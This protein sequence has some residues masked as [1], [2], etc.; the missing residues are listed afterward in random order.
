MLHT[1]FI[2]DENFVIPT[3]VAISSLIHNNP[4]KELKVHVVTPG[5]SEQAEKTLRGMST[6]N[7][8]VIVYNVENDLNSMSTSGLFDGIPANHTALMKF[9]LPLILKD[10][11]KL[12]YL[13]GDLIVNGDI[14]PIWDVELGD[15]LVAGVCDSIAEWHMQK[16]GLKKYFNSGVM[17][18]NLKKMRD[19]NYSQKLIDY[20]QNGF[21]CFMDQDT[22]NAVFKNRVKYLDFKY[23]TMYSVLETKSADEI[24]SFY[25]MKRRTVNELIDDSVI[26]HFSSSKKPWKYILPGL[27]LLYGKYVSLSP[28]KG[29]EFAYL[30]KAKSICEEE[31]F[32]RYADL[33]EDKKISVIVPAH[34][35]ED[36]VK[37]CVDSI[38]NQTLK[39]IE[40][41]IVDDAST[42]STPE[43][44]DEYAKKDSRVRVIH[45]ETNVGTCKARKLGVEISTGRFIMFVDGDDSIRLDSCE[46]L[47]NE[48]LVNDYDIL[49]FKTAVVANGSN[50]NVVKDFEKYINRSFGFLTSEELIEKSF[51]KK[52]L[53]RN[54]WNR[55]YKGNIVRCAMRDLADGYYLKSEDLYTSLLIAFE[56]KNIGFT[57]TEGYIYSMGLGITSTTSAISVD[58]YKNICTGIDVVKCIADYICEHHNDKKYLEMMTSLFTHCFTESNWWLQYVADVDVEQCLDICFTKYDALLPFVE[59]EMM[60]IS[61]AKALDAMFLTVKKAFALIERRVSDFISKISSNEEIFE[62]YSHIYHNRIMND[63]GAVNI[64]VNILNKDFP[65]LVVLLESIYQSRREDKFYNIYV[66]GNGIYNKNMD[67]THKYNTENMSVRF[68]NNCNGVST[69]IRRGIDG[70]L[71]YKAYA[72]Y[73]L[74]YL[75]K[76]IYLSYDSTVI[77][78][79]SKLADIDLD[80]KIFAAVHDYSL[81]NGEQIASSYATNLLLIDRVAFKKRNVVEAYFASNSKENERGFLN[82]EFAGMIKPLDL[83]WCFKWQIPYKHLNGKITTE[84]DIIQWG[85]DDKPWK[86]PHRIYADVFWKYARSTDFYEEIL[87]ENSSHRQIAVPKQEELAYH[88]RSLWERF[89]IGC[90][91]IGFFATVKKA[92]KKAFRKVFKRRR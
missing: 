74:Q 92:I 70:N 4:Q 11:D 58:K 66:F 67:R 23:N 78:D 9:N 56:S 43:I 89:K 61:L 25:G 1:A 22:F 36:S 81:D 69:N 80:G 87:Y 45:C 48:M 57:D 68:V 17:L 29:H 41:I 90:R 21:N 39:D 54:L 77:G 10:V 86:S 75:D 65:Y 88:Q 51:V 3:S 42:D 2:C 20:R 18:L 82:K 27:C 91:E 7:S 53:S 13:D 49:Q 52:E 8:E 16:L 85:S 30:G 34:N 31:K 84:Y 71:A 62:K 44:I 24:A 79:I 38:V 32:I 37:A 83:R 35:V 64:A 6:N 50:E 14:S 63:K 55:I 60:A 73:F 28:F 40:V 59:N 33:T 15:D 26:L 47:Y 12:L 72:M 19:E 76:V 5:V 46:K